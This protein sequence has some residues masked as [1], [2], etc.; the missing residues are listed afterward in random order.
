MNYLEEAAREVDEHRKKQFALLAQAELLESDPGE[1][2][3]EELLRKEQLKTQKILSE[4]KNIADAES[5]KG[6]N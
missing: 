6:K 3:I 4:A 1:L 2:N 5:A